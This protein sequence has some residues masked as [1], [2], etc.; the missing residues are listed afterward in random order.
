[1]VGVF[2][3]AGMISYTDRVI[4]SAI[5]DPMRRDLAI[6][7]TQVSLLQ[8]AA[9]AIVYVLAGLPFGRLADRARRVRVVIAG[10]VIWSLGTIACGLAPSFWALFGARLIVGIG[11]AALFPA[12]VSIAADSFPPAR[13]GTAVGIMLSGV[14]IGGSAA[15]AIG[16]IVLGAAQSGAFAQ[17]PVV[18][19]LAP[20]RTVLVLVGVFGL[21]VPLLC[22]TIAEPPRR[23]VTRDQGTSLGDVVALFV[24]QRQLL[25]PLYIGM[26]LLSIGDYGVLS[27]GPSVLTRRFLFQPAQMGASFGIIT[28]IGGVVGALIGGSVSDLAQRR[29]GSAGRLAMIAAGAVLAAIGALLVSGGTSLIVLAGLGLWMFASTMA[30]TA[31]IATLGVIVPNEVRGVSISIVAFCNTLLGLGG[32]PTLVALA[33]DHVY[34]NPLTVG[35]AITTTVL[36]AA[37][38]AAALFARSSHLLRA[39]PVP[40]ARS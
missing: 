5:V 29:A 14:I 10:V 13:R 38:L 17:W 16:G 23:D 33:T 25:V 35:L 32:G 39:A 9:F 19:T 7:D 11:E 22:A 27:W 24:K 4:L 15:A 28:A 3:L 12:A 1:M 40:A 30:A 20:W 34:H 31:G 6:S 36:P 21:V 37:V 26:G 2:W 8:G 18:A